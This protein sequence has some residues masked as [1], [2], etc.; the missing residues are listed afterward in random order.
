MQ[1]GERSEARK[2]TEKQTKEIEKRKKGAKEARA[3]Q[4]EEKASDLVSKRA[5]FDWKENL[6]HRDLIS[7][8]GFSRLISP[9]QEIIEKRG[10]HLFCE[11]K[12]PGF[13]DMVKEFYSNMVGMKEN[14]VYVKGK[15]I[16]FS[17]GKIDQTFNLNERKNC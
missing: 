2:E 6:Q 9:F 10:R 8:R 3:E 17:R 14:T 15:W 11:H 16:S 13:V 1:E 4:R 7:E 5:Y 12:A